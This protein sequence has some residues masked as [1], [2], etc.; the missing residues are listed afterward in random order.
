VDVDF[1]RAGHC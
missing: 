1:M